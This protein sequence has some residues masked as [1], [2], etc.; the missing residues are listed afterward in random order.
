MSLKFVQLKRASLIVGDKVVLLRLS[1]VNFLP[2][3]FMKLVDILD[4]IR[5]REARCLI[6]RA[7]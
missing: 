1:F 3:N 4:V 7:A 2:V 5:L 6:S